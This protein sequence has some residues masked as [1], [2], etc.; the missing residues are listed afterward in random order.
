RKLSRR[1]EAAYGSRASRCRA[2]SLSCGCRRPPRSYRMSSRILLV[3]D[4][5]G[6]V[7]TVS[8]LLAAE[9]YQVESALDGDSGLAKALAGG[10][11][12]IVLDIMLPKRSGYEVCR[13][14]RQRGV[15]TAILM[16]T[17]KSQV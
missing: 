5:P 14:L 6:L 1:M 8:D 3:E 15:D 4:E 16:L 11:S 10:F 13:E 17:A 9:G 2:R 12:V 7:M